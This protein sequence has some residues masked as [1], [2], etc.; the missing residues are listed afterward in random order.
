MTLDL[1]LTDDL[2][3]LVLKNFS[4]N[5]R[6]SRKEQV[7]ADREDLTVQTDLVYHARNSNFLFL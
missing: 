4:S 6:G 2:V 3:G 7:D 1:S 5:L